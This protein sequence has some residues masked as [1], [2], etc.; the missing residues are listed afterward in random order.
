MIKEKEDP[1]TNLRENDRKIFNEINFQGNYVE[2]DPQETQKNDEGNQNKNEDT[3]EKE[4]PQQLKREEQSE[5][6]PKRK[7]MTLEEI[8]D[9]FWEFIDDNNHE[10]REFIIKD[11]RRGTIA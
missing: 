3:L 11:P 4:E 6:S 5:E 9:E 8:Y 10:F 7:E 1:F 2:Y